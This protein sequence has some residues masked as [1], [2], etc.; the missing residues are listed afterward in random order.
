MKVI[1]D[2]K[3]KKMATSLMELL[4]NMEFIEILK[5]IN[6]PKKEEMIRDISE[7]FNEVRLHMKGKKKLRSAR[8]MLNEI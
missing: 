4:K 7:S 1:L 6:D 8:T 5:V 2:I 3:N